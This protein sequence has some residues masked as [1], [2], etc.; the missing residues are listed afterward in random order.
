[1]SPSAVEIPIP[2]PKAL[3]TAFNDDTKSEEL[4][5]PSSPLAEVKTFHASSCNVE[6][7]VSAIRVAGGVV[8]KD[9]LNKD[10]IAELEKDT[11]PWL[12]QDTPWGKGQFSTK[13]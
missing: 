7:L 9:M 2:T 11:R 3:T 12:E 6:D 5:S 8:I 4:K 1:M 10:E 13:P